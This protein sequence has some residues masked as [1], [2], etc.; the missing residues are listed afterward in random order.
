[1]YIH[2]GEQISVHDSSVIGI[3][4]IENTTIGQDTRALRHRL[5]DE[6]NVVN[7]SQDMPKSFILCEDEN[8]ENAYVSPISAATL[9]KRA[10][11][12]Y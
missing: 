7:V 10:A 3:F 1:M 11:K 8:G 4:D 12:L 6:K 2:L 9:R 5:E